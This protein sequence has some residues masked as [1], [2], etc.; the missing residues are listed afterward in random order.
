MSIPTTL[1]ACSVFV[2]LFGQPQSRSGEAP[3]I[4][5][6]APAQTSDW[7]KNGAT[8][9]TKLLTADFRKAILSHPAGT[10][11]AQDAYSCAFAG[12]SGGTIIKIEL[13]DHLTLEA[14]KAYNKIDRP[15]AIALAG[16][17]D[18]ALR[19][20]NP[21]VVDAWKKGDRNCRVMLMAIEEQPKLT[22]DALAKKLGGICNQLFALP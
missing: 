4:A 16:V 8:A 5:S 13:A 20:D 21:T 1:V 11:K 6:V 22:G 3:T 12:D 18:Q 17:G 10:S 19:I 2:V 9:C 15:A 14:W 7:A